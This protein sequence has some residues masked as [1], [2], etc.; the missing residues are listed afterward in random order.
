MI[1]KTNGQKIS[2]NLTSDEV[3]LLQE[4]VPTELMDFYKEELKKFKTSS[5]KEMASLRNRF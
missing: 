5:I 1:T 2:S 3:D 4:F